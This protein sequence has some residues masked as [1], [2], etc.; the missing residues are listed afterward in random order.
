MERRRWFAGQRQE[1]ADSSQ[2]LSSQEAARPRAPVAWASLSVQQLRRRE[3]VGLTSAFVST[4][5]FLLCLGAEVVLPPVPH[6]ATH[7]SDPPPSESRALAPSHSC[8]QSTIS[9]PPLMLLQLALQLD[10]ALWPP[11]SPPNRSCPSASSP[12]LQ[13]RQYVDSESPVTPQR[14]ETSPSLNHRELPRAAS[15]MLASAPISA[16]RVPAS[17][18]PRL[19]LLDNKILLY[20]VVKKP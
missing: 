7:L 20:F 8:P 13:Q 9:R 18:W 12:T 17:T 11:V 16:A 6:F 14:A 1:A 5:R 3:L 10:C 19:A 15:P 2:G 4:S